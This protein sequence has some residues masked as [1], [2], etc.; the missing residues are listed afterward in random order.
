MKSGW[1]YYGEVRS[2]AGGRKM[3]ASV[4]RG[5]VKVTLLGVVAG[6]V[7]GGISHYSGFLLTRCRGLFPSPSVAI[8]AVL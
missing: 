2:R 8:P 1:S 5:D 3:A 6:V 4:R 7:V